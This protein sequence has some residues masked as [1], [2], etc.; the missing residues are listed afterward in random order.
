MQIVRASIAPKIPRVEVL[1]YLG[2]VLEVAE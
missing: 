2:H 1:H